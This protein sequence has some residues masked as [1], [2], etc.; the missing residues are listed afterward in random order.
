M[1]KNTFISELSRKLRGLPKADYDDAMNI[2]GMNAN[3][4]GVKK[5]AAGNRMNEVKT[6]WNWARK[7]VGL[8]SVYGVRED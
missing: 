6:H 8:A 3:L 1:N 4:T 2:I 5:S 7:I